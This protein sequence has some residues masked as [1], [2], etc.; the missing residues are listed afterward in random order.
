MIICSPITEIA[1]KKAT[2]L[3]PFYPMF[4][5]EPL[6]TKSPSQLFWISLLTIRH[7]FPPCY[8]PYRVQSNHKIKGRNFSMEAAFIASNYTITKQGN[9]SRAF[10]K[11]GSGKIPSSPTVRQLELQNQQILFSP[12]RT[13]GSGKPLPF[14]PNL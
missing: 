9:S 7:Q 12:S 4:N 10:N 1:A 11:K 3:L 8:L 14:V 13:E 6:G 2:F 5:S